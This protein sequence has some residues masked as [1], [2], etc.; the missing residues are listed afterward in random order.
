MQLSRLYIFRDDFKKYENPRKKK[1][2]SD[3]FQQHHI[4]YAQTHSLYTVAHIAIHTDSGNSFTAAQQRAESVS[5]PFPSEEIRLGHKRPADKS[6]LHPRCGQLA[7]NEMWEED[8]TLCAHVCI[9]TSIKEPQVILAFIGLFLPEILS[10]VLGSCIPSAFVRICS[11]ALGTR[12]WLYVIF[13]VKWNSSRYYLG[14]ICNYLFV[15]SIEVA[16]SKTRNMSPSHLHCAINRLF[17]VERKSARKEE[18]GE[19]QARSIKATRAALI[20]RVHKSP[21][22]K[23]PL[24]PDVP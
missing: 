17:S 16:V 24:L 13:F 1:F 2:T 23:T 12:N 7:L 22:D 5:L 19:F 21:R 9:Y 11:F 6:S 4:S 20:L 3:H 8:N 15:I 10:R 14:K 18:K